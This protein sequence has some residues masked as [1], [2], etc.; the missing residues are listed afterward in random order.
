MYSETTTTTTT[1]T[2]TIAAAAAVVVVVVVIVAPRMGVL[3][4]IVTPRVV[5]MARSRRVCLV[6]KTPSLQQ[7][8]ALQQDS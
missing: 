3:G 5:V 8:N 2:T 4:V 6:A 7:Q 1:T